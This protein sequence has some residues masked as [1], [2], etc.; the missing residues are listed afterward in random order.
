MDPL[1]L[2]GLTYPMTHEYATIRSPKRPTMVL[3]PPKLRG[4]FNQA[5]QMSRPRLVANR[6]PLV[7]HVR[8]IVVSPNIPAA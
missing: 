5:E 1:E 2:L 3:P 8:G 7:A 6:N 4:I